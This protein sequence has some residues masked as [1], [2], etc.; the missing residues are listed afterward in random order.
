MNRILGLWGSRGER[1]RWGRE[2]E[3]GEYDGRLEFDWKND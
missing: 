2:R 1:S 3:I